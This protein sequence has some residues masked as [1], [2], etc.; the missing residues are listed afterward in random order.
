V[1]HSANG[2]NK[3]MQ[4]SAGKARTIFDKKSRIIEG[5][6]KRSNRMQG[7]GVGCVERR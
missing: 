4:S 6:C 5:N 1:V 2:I 3:I 7:Y